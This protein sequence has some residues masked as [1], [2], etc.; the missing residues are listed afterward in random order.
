MTRNERLKINLFFCY[1]LTMKIQKIK[2]S[3]KKIE[4]FLVEEWS[5]AD[6]KHFGWTMDWQEQEYHLKVIIGGKLAGYINFKIEAGVCTIEN[7]IIADEHQRKGIGRQLM[8]EAEKIAKQSKVHKITL[9]TG[10][11]WP[12]EKF[13]Q[14]LGYKQT[15]TLEK[16]SFKKDHVVYSKFI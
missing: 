2:K 16:H 10:Q 11:G 14:A 13:Y 5:K 4:E 7:L 15:G 6:L 8:K 1:Y 12:S 9:S 3:N